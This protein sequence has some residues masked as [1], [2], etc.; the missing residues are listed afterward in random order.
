MTKSELLERAGGLPFSPGVYIMK[1]RTGTVIY[2][3]KSKVL[4]QR[5]SQYFQDTDHN[6]KTARMVS[7]ADSFDY[8]L[9]DT[10]MEALALENRLIKMHQPKYNIR[11][12]DAKSYPYIK[13]T[14]NNEYPAI[15]V[16]RSR[17]NDGARY[18]GPYSSANTAYN[19][20]RTVQRIFRISNCKKEFPRDIGKER[21]CMYK[22]IGQ[23]IGPCSGEIS[24][25]EYRTVFRDVITFLRGCYGE[26]KKSLEEK[27]EFCSENL[28]FENAALYRDRIKSLEVLW[29]KQKVVGSPDADQDVFAFYTDDVSSCLAVFYV[30]MG[31]LA[32]SE[33]FMFTPD[34]ICDGDSL[35]SFI[36]DLYNK[37]EYVPKEILIGFDV[38]ES[39]GDVLYDYLRDMGAK[40]KLRFPERGD[41]KALC[42][43][44]YENAKNYAA[45]YMAE[46]ER[47]N[48]ML[49]RLASLLGLEVVPQRIEA[50]DV[51]NMGKENIVCGMILA[52]DGKFR[53]SGY[54]CFNIK[55]VSGQD[56][57][58]AMSEA[59]IRRMEHTSLRSGNDT[60]PDLILLD[61]GRG[62][63]STIRRVLGEMGINIPVFGMVKDEY[64]KTRALSNDHEDISIARE[65]A[66]FT[67]IYKI[68]EEVHRYTVGRMS[69]AHSR[70]LK[71]SSLEDIRGIGPMKS[72][73]LLLHFKTLTAIKRASEAE[74]SEVE[75][76]SDSDASNIYE[77]FHKNR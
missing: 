63:V 10:E 67:F 48:K 59:V 39:A 77:H 33:F 73:A 31:F 18:F 35:T 46:Q 47:D 19:I 36:G 20:I 7:Q 71:R 9:T 16:V 6:I 29:E 75:G 4:R 42:D 23:C 13:V 22:Q 21:P 17:E 34:M 11:L 51:S 8:I 45:Q 76:I 60:P 26:A 50:Y 5:V 27:M 30:R 44:V 49:I 25:E 14:I 64:H 55:S 74:L 37:R 66:V 57:Y 65:Q 24:G 54:R 69:E 43:M 40:T 32:D 53:K 41:M 72:K 2:V 15:S 38:G 58:A 52:E 68:Q 12:K 62:H 28:M 61:G 70:N 1:N 3:G 56:D